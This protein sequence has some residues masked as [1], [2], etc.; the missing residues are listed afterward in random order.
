MERER[1]WSAKDAKGR[2][3]RE[4]IGVWN[5]RMRSGGRE[6]VMTVSLMTSVV[7]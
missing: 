4:R 1:L 3:S 6:R 2:E 5:V 7:E